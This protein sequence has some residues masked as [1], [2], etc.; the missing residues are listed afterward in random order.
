MVVRGIIARGTT[1]GVIRGT[2]TCSYVTL[3][4][5]RVKD[6]LTAVTLKLERIVEIRSRLR[7]Q[8]ELDDVTGM[9]GWDN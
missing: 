3:P 2:C 9:G 1:V 7:R 5:P 8:A 6:P 4:P